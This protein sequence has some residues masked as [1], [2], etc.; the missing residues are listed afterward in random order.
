MHF[1]F[2]FLAI[3]PILFL[4]CMRF[5]PNATIYVFMLADFHT[6]W[7]IYDSEWYDAYHNYLVS[8]LPERPEGPI[9]ELDGNNFTVE[10]VVKLSRD[11]TFPL[12]IRNLLENTTGVQQW[13]SPDWWVENYGEERILCGTLESVRPYCTIK[14]FFDELKQG[15]PF[16]VTGASKIFTRHPELAAMV[17][18]DK[19][20]PIEPGTR[21]STQIFMGL[22]EM[23]SD[24]HCAVGVNM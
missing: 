17:N 11:Y 19:L 5:Y 12:V 15:K 23:G 9:P 18:E 22:P 14:D 24:I 6:S 20:L 4:L 7:K 8:T 10:D 13:Q 2:K 1:F 3:L 16:Y 21:M